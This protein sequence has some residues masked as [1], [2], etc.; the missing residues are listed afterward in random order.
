M[1]LIFEALAR[2]IPFSRWPLEET[3]RYEGLHLPYGTTIVVVTALL[4]EPLR[5]ALLHLH[6]RGFALALITLGQAGNT[7][8]I[9]GVRRYHI[10]GREEWHEL[11]SISLH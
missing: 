7:P 11:A 3:L 4:T 10:G 5:Q 2:I 9:P 1:T 8:L 6:D